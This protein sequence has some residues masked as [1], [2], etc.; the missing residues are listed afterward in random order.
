[1]EFIDLKAQ[2]RKYK[3][4]IDKSI[5]RV[6]ESGDFIL[7]EE[8]SKFELELE[9]KIGTKCITVAN[10]TDAIFIVLKALGIKE[11]DEV[12]VPS[13]TWVSTAEVVKLAGA[14]P[15]FC[16]IN[17]TSFNI[18][19][20]EIEKHISPNTRAII[21]VS[22]F[23]QCAEL[24][25]IKKIAERNKIFLIEDAA[26][27]FGAKHYKKYSCSIADFSTTSFFPS[28]PLGCYGDGGAIFYKNYD[29]EE[30]IRT[31]PRHGQKGRYNYINIGVN[32]RLDSLQ[33]A[34]LSTKLKFLD[35]ELKKKNIVH[36]IYEH[37]LSKFKE[38]QLPVIADYNESS[39]AI[40]S[41]KVSDNRTREKLYEFLNMENIPVGKY[42]PVPLHQSAPYLSETNLPITEDDI[43]E[44]CVNF[45]KFYCV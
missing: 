20:T 8:V 9:E 36:E 37:Y 12:I 13:F 18:E 23:G 2:Y 33:A 29:F 44:I 1:M 39:N 45:E 26:Q 30:S 43:R 34:I 27:S 15:I 4:E 14:K 41:I 16:D 5:A 10:G 25:D 6:I 3:N 31:I 7:G 32:S 28:K 40:Y 42:Y 22:I 11:G 24:L 17:G 35:D 38:I 19:P 21:A